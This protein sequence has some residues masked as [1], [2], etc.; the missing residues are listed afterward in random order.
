M[1]ALRH[2]GKICTRLLTWPV[3]WWFGVGMGMTVMWLDSLF[4]DDALEILTPMGR[5]LFFISWAI[6]SGYVASQIDTMATGHPDFGKP[7]SGRRQWI[8]KASLVFCV[9]GCA[10]AFA[11][12][13]RPLAN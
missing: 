11:F 1:K 9:L 12:F 7:K 4:N 5:W 2:I 6:G 3:S 10:V 8:E 13:G